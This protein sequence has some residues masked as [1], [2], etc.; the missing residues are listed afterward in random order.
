MI[1]KYLDLVTS[2]HRTK[3][4]FI[5]WLTAA[6]EKTEDA[7]NATSA[8]LEAFDLDNAVGAQLDIIGTVI[9]RTR[10]LNFD[11]V[12][13]TPK[14]DDNTYRLILKAKILQN[15]WGGT[16]P[17][18]Q[19]IWQTVFPQYGLIIQDNQ[20]MTMKATV[21]GTSSALENNLIHNNY[22]VP[23]PA[24]VSIVYEF[25]EINDLNIYFGFAVQDGTFETIQQTI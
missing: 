21:V 5:A 10:Y 2:E 22:I 8:T 23:K 12:Q 4:N 1:Q 9:G 17:E 16:I 20:D 13:G 6:L 3:E 7:A 14:L 19:A 11:P 18:I 25:T 15:Q 24:G